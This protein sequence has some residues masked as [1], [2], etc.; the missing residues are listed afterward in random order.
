MP[1]AM[2]VTRTMSLSGAMTIART[3]PTSNND[4][5]KYEKGT[6]KKVSKSFVS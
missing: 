6:L 3:M 1:G 2:A 5:W 4:D